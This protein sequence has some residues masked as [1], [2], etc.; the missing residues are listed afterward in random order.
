MSEFETW[1]SSVLDLSGRYAHEDDMKWAL[2]SM[3]IH[4]DSKYGSLP[5]R[6]FVTRLRKAAANQIASAVFQ[7]IKIKQQAANQ[8]AD[9]TPKEGST[10]D[11]QE[12]KQA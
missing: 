9:T 10:A 12:A 11:V 5:K 6:Y 8:V 3:I 1:A 7:D 2:A 4:A